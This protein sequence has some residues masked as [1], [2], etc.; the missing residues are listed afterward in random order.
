MDHFSR[1]IAAIAT[2][3]TQQF[4]EANNGKN[5][6]RGNDDPEEVVVK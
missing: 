6:E 1:K 2:P 3:F 5:I 4:R